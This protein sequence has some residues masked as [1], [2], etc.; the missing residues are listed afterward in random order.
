[1]LIPRNRLALERVIIA[2]DSGNEGKPGFSENLYLEVF[3]L[4]LGQPETDGSQPEGAQ[5]PKNLAW[6]ATT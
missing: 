5:Q 6:L 2:P 3:R 4:V 1:M